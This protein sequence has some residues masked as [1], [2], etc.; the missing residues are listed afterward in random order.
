MSDELFSSLKTQ[1][2]KY[3]LHFTVAT[4]VAEA[5]QL[6]HE[7]TYH[8]LLVDLEYL[9]NVQQTD[10]LS[11]VRRI[12]F[13]PVVILTDTPEL[14]MTNMIGLGM[15]ICVSDRQSHPVIADMI[16]AQVRRYTEYN[17]YKDPRGAKSAPFC[18]GDIL[19]D[20]LRYVVEVQG[21]TVNL[22]PREF[23]CCCISCRIRILS[24]PPSKYVSRL[25]I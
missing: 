8:L 4:T 12:S 20:P 15:D 11:S 17:H 16:Y 7:K 5:N 9:R 21:Q 3:R 1:L 19:I 25:G 13:V 2:A 18:L 6:L 22:R 24:Y 14:D 23:F 10:W